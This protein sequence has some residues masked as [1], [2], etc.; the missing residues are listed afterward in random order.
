MKTK[1][2]TIG[3]KIFGIA[4]V[5]VCLMVAL[6]ACSIILFDRV[7]HE[8]VV[9][10]EVFLPTLNWVS[11][12]EASVLKTAALMEGLRTDQTIDLGTEEEIEELV[13]NFVAFRDELEQRLADVHRIIHSQP[14]EWYSR[15]SLVAATRIDA[16]IEAIQIEHEDYYQ[17]I[18]RIVGALRAG[19]HAEALKSDAMFI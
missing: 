11:N 9:Q 6:S 17:E 13:E 15:D 18:E 16:G 19:R 12:I 8:L 10:K 5:L 4:I 3:A 2:L 14:L 1:G 7:R